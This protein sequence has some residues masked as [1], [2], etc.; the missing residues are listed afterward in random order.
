LDELTI[1]YLE[2]LSTGELIELAAQ[3]GLD[4]P[5]GLERVFIIEEL[6]YL[7]HK[8]EDPAQHDINHGDKRHDDFKEY[9]VLP[10][11]YHVSFVEVL[12]RDPLWAFVFW[13]IK[14]YDKYHNEDA[15]GNEGYCLRV[16][17][18]KEGPL[19]EGGLQPDR[20][21]SFIVAVD[22]DDNGRY[23]GFPPDEER[24]YMIELCM[25]NHESF[26][27]LAESRPFTLPCLIKPKVDTPVS[28]CTPVTTASN[29]FMQA[30]YRNPLAQ[31]SGVDRFSLVHSEDRRLR[32]RDSV[33]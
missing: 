4:I 33:E 7:G 27:V 15:E 14:A 18:L 31:L 26:T 5:H 16:I 28:S 10:R 13:E 30:V 9:K 17:P 19:K 32:P 23:L 21:A 2:S 29:E 25:Q 12:V 20:S 8:A 6:F 11:Q 22:K 1:P 3:H 24:R